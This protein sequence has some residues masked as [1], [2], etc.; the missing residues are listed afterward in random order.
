MK[1]CEI[2]G[3]ALGLS[4][5]LSPLVGAQRTT[6]YGED[7]ARR[8]VSPSEVRQVTGTKARLKNETKAADP[9][10]VLA[11]LPFEEIK[12]A[13][14]EL[15]NL[16]LSRPTSWEVPPWPTVD[17]ASIPIPDETSSGSAEVW[18]ELTADGEEA[19]Y[20]A[21][22]RPRAVPLDQQFVFRIKEIPSPFSLRRYFDNEEVFVEVAAYGGTTSFKAEEAF[23]ALKEAATRQQKL[24]GIGEEAF[25]TRIEVLDKSWV[26]PKLMPFEELPPSGEVRPDLLD[27]GKAE[28]LLA[29][30]FQDLPVKDLEGQTITYVEPNKKYL[31]AQPEV[32]QSLLVIVS[33]FP[34]QA[35]TVS[36]AMEERLGTVQDLVALS[37][38]VQRRLLYEIKP[39]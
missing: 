2:I 10:F 3:L 26:D 16:T 33:F 19:V 35:L 29:P 20:S 7:L 5:L 22:L 17:P 9:L 38:L 18:P 4:L 34:D 24:E 6:L 14:N 15:G 30:S 27:S 1:K 25:L 39:G 36:V 32:K 23:R 28:A 31:P 21:R 8:L 13:P 12:A 11:P 37:M